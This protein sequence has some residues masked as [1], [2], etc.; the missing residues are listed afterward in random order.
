MFDSFTDRG[1]VVL[2]KQTGHDWFN[3][4][5]L[6]SEEVTGSNYRRF[7]E[8]KRKSKQSMKVKNVRKVNQA[9]MISEMKSETLPAKR[10]QSRRKDISSERSWG[11]WFRKRPSRDTLA[12]KGIL[13]QGYFGTD[14]PDLIKQDKVAHFLLSRELTFPVL[15]SSAGFSH[16]VH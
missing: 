14:I 2:R 6:R 16:L 1:I 12:K 7:S 10:G 11:N 3:A 13:K 15:A 4:I 8:K 9:E 5:S